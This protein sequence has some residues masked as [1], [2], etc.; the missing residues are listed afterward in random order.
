MYTDVQVTR[1]TYTVVVI[2]IT[3]ILQYV[4]QDCYTGTEGC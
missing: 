3:N 1:Y 2:S 4:T